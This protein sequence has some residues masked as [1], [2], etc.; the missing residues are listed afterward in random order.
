M[1]FTSMKHPQMNTKTYFVSYDDVHAIA[2]YWYDRSLKVWTVYQ[3][4]RA[5]FEGNQIGAA[6][7]AYSKEAA[8]EIAMDIARQEWWPAARG[9]YK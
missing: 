7:H 6:Q 2:S 9:E 4:S 3:I 1:R 8:E 5:D